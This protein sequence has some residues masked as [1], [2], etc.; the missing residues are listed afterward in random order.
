MEINNINNNMNF[1]AKLKVSLGK[2]IENYLQGLKPEESV[3][4]SQ[5]IIDGVGLLKK[6]APGIGKEEDLIT[7]TDDT[8]GYI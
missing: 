2:N 3:W 4:Y 5:E 7:V 8:P 6:V 1:K